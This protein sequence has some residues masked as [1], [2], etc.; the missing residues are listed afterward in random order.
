[1]DFIKAVKLG[2]GAYLEFYPINSAQLVQRISNI[3]D[4]ALNYRERLFAFIKEYK[5]L[6]E[7]SCPYTKENEDEILRILKKPTREP[8]DIHRLLSLANKYGLLNIIRELIHFPSVDDEL[9]CGAIEAAVKQGVFDFATEIFDVLEESLSSKPPRD[10]LRF[11]PRALKEMSIDFIK[12]FMET[13]KLIELRARDED[14]LFIAGLVPGVLEVCKREEA[15]ETKC[16]LLGFAREMVLAN[17]I[18]AHSK[19]CVLDRI[20]PI[21]IQETMLPSIALT[22]GFAREI[23]GSI[24]HE[25]PRYREQIV[26]NLIPAMGTVE[27]VDIQD[28][29]LKFARE[30][31]HGGVIGLLRF[32]IINKA[33][34]VAKDIESAAIRNAVFG[35]AREILAGGENAQCNILSSL[36]VAFSTARSAKTAE[37]Q[38]DAIVFAREIFSGVTEESHSELTWILQGA[39]RL[40]PKAKSVG[41]Q[42]EAISFATAIFKRADISEIHRKAI[43]E[44]LLFAVSEAK[45]PVI[46]EYIMG[47]AQH[48]Y[49]LGVFK[50]AAVSE[51]EAVESDSD[52][53]ED[54][55][56][57]GL[58]NDELDA[59]TVLE[60]AVTAAVSAQTDLVKES[61]I[62]VAREV[63]VRGDLTFN[64]SSIFKAIEVAKAKDRPL[65]REVFKQMEERLDPWRKQ[66]YAQLLDQESD[67]RMK[68]PRSSS[69]CSFGKRAHFG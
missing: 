58:G 10:Q 7:G 51:G 46:Q 50:G 67:G 25:N 63:M 14:N 27:N 69:W 48:V 41:L 59:G 17:R 34:S 31:F 16:S 4:M 6:P 54:D 13:P 47:F 8:R 36:G 28:E 40:I 56:D 68:A 49:G 43:L 26:A 53:D 37:I 42:E 15:P 52:S 22:F 2:Y 66:H 12:K 62:R 57:G 20:I 32:D 24:V 60:Y 19:L 64:H 35:F 29:I 1:M 33:A 38:S 11:L 61:A 39:I 3:A 30:I 55:D 5:G 45:T 9:R 23:A 18:S 65:A 21:A 44:S